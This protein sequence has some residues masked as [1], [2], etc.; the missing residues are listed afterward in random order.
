MKKKHIDWANLPFDYKKT[1]YR[2]LAT[3]KNGSWDEGKLIQDNEIHLHS[4]SFSKG[5]QVIRSFLW[6]RL[7][8]PTQNIAVQVQRENLRFSLSLYKFENPFY[9]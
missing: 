2:F 6:S 8:K 7:L 9:K 5:R 1:D 3:Y 4:F